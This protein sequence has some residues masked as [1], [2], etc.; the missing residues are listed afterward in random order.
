MVDLAAIVGAYEGLMAAKHLFGGF[1]DAKADEAAKL[2]IQTAMEQVGKAQDTLYQL[3]DELFI[4]QGKNDE[5]RRALEE[6]DAW[7]QASAR[8]AL[9]RTEGGAVVYQYNA[10]PH[11]YACPSCYNKKQIQPLQDNRTLRGKFRCT[12]CCAE[13]PIKPSEKSR[14]LQYPNGGGFI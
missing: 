6:I 10:E 13:Y 2:K 7:K 4:T 11:H 8:Y 12:A 1:I 14:P 3:R 5:L 9:T